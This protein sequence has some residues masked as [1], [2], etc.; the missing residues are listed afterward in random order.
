MTYMQ[1]PVY[2]QGVLMLW[3]FLIQLL[4]LYNFFSYLQIGNGRTRVRCLLLNLGNYLLLQVQA[5]LRDQVWIMKPIVNWPANVPVGM[6]VLVTAL[7]LTELV[8]I[9]KWNG[10]HLSDNSIKEAMDQLPT[11]LGYALPDGLPL[12]VNERMDQLYR[13]LFRTPLNNA[14]EG[15]NRISA[16]P[17]EDRIYGGDPQE[18]QKI[19][20][21]PD[22]GVIGFQR[23]N[24]SMPEGEVVELLATD[25]SKEYALTLKLQEKEKQ[26]RAMNARLKSLIGTIEYVTMSRELL[27]LKV[28]LHDNIGQ[29]ILLS[30]QYLLSPGEENRKLLL[31]QWLT[32]ARHLMREEP[33]HWQAPYYVNSLEAA[34]MGITLDIAG[35]LP[36]EEKLMPVVDQ[37]ISAHVTNV[38]RHADGKVARIRVRQTK[39]GYELSFSNDGKAP[40][41]NVREMGGLAN[42]RQKVEEVGGSMEIHSTPAFELVLTL[43]V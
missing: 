31:D 18:G 36:R 23:K 1:L 3:T 7:G 38:L 6:L 39:E 19:V 24:I 20:R 33:E 37:A 11:G 27:R 29:C 28:A 2:L 43:P 5:G 9:R 16:L 32:N 12:L 21:L 10:S 41:E 35:E 8:R 40:Q 42:L 25:L 17:G 15:W 22:G 4:L 13:E 14:E 34:K 26:A 30:K